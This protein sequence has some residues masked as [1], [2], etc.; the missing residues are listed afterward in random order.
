MT[1]ETEAKPRKARRSML[2]PLSR[3]Q[4][5]PPGI[6]GVSEE[7]AEANRAARDAFDQTEQAQRKASELAE[8]AHA[9]A[10]FDQLA[11]EAALAVGEKPPKPTAER[12][13]AAAQEAKQH[14]EAAEQVA[15]QKVRELYD[16]LEDEFP[17]YLEARRKDAEQAVEP[18]R[19][20]PSDYLKSWIEAQSAIALHEDAKRWHNN[21]GSASLSA[22]I[23]R[24]ERLRGRYERELADQ[25]GARPGTPVERNVPALLAALTLLAE[26]GIG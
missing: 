15:K 26:E 24:N 3:D 2:F 17:A 12:K 1:T 5:L 25:R 18:L 7:A 9:A 13:Q 19:Q 23:E 8:Q 22:G 4:L 20:M 16:R 6:E 21:P 10:R 11:T 14:A